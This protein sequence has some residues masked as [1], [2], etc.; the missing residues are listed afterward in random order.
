MYYIVTF[1]DE[2]VQANPNITVRAFLKAIGESEFVYSK[3]GTTT[4]V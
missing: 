4:L 3:S 1:E 2:I